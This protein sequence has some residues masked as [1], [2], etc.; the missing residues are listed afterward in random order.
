MEFLLL[1]QFNIRLNTRL[2]RKEFLNHLKLSKTTLYVY[3]DQIQLVKI[4][5]ED[6]RLNL[7]F[8]HGTLA[9]LLDTIRN[10][11]T[12]KEIKITVNINMN[13]WYSAEGEEEEQGF[14]KGVNLNFRGS[15]DLKMGVN[16]NF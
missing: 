3:E 12:F 5:K 14:P 11:S 6:K 1:P 4:N 13:D 10:P 7:S 9:D 2:K 15:I 16:M 8:D